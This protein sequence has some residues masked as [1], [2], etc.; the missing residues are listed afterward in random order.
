MKSNASSNSLTLFFLALLAYAS[1]TSNPIDFTNITID[2]PEN[3]TYTFVQAA[4]FTLEDHAHNSKGE[5]IVVGSQWSLKKNENIFYAKINNRGETTWKNNYGGN[6]HDKAMALYVDDEDQSFV[7]GYKHVPGEDKDIRLDFVNPKGKTT[8]KK[9]YHFLPNKTEEAYQMIPFQEDYIITGFNKGDLNGFL[10][11]ISKDGEAKQHLSA[12]GPNKDYLFDVI[13]TD[14][15]SL[16]AVGSYSSFYDLTGNDFNVKKSK[17][18]LIKTNDELEL[19]W[20]KQFEYPGHAMGHKIIPKADNEFFIIAS[21]QTEEQKSFQAMLIVVDA[22]G[23]KQWEK[24]FGGTSWDYAVDAIVYNQQIYLLS[25]SGDQNTKI[26]LYK[27]DLQG[28]LVDTFEYKAS[29]DIEAKS[30][31]IRHEE[32]IIGGN[33]KRGNVG[34]GMIIRQPID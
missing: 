22:Q 6:G 34:S 23:K 19:L 3:F 15:D 7:L 17:I 24:S 2:G 26:I 16:L 31:S 28:N 29:Q 27:L 10:F 33:L 14:E 20:E 8:Q 5:I 9:Q 11:K 12:G 21:C 25:N 30:L 32:I 13:A 18:Y 4:D 1:C